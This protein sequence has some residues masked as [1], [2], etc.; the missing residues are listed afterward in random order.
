M[1]P[2]ETTVEMVARHVREG[3]EHIAQQRMI[4]EGLRARGHPTKEAEDFLATFVQIQRG[5]EEHLARL[6]AQRWL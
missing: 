5:H 6:R 3:R 2:R 1:A 4:I